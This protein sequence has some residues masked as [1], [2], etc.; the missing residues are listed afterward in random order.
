MSFG[1]MSVCKFL[2]RLTHFTHFFFY[3]NPRWSYP[4]LQLITIYWPDFGKAQ[5]RSIIRKVK[6]A[7]KVEDF[8]PVILSIFSLAQRLSIPESLFP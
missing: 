7:L 3:R 1:L 8:A 5:R 2:V 6:E 4:H